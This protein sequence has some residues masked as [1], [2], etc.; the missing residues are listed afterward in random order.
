MVQKW[1]KYL[2]FYFISLDL[3]S[4]RLSG[5][6]QNALRKRG[7]WANIKKKAAEAHQELCETSMM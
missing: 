5:E 7:K 4:W 1:T 6:K 3:C 2:Y